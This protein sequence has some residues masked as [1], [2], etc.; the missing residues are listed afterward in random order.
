MSVDGPD[1]GPA[2][3]TSES[4]FKQC[5]QAGRRRELPLVG[6]L[7]ESQRAF[8][9]H[10]AHREILP[11]VA[12]NMAPSD[13]VQ[14]TLAKAYEKFDSFRGSTLAE[15]RGWLRRILQNAC[16]DVVRHYSSLK[17][18]GNGVCE[19]PHELASGSSN[20]PSHQALTEEERH[21]LYGG[22][23]QLSEVHRKVILLRNRDNLS[24]SEIGQ[25]LEKSSEAARKL[26][27][28]AILQLKDILGSDESSDAISGRT[29][30]P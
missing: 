25:Q 14:D 20:S 10:I 7:L 24:F 23:A 12:A 13:L 27:G 29:A 18:N 3:D 5:V 17:R 8:L 16:V 26:W 11:I 1:D 4:L 21:R 30:A 2:D 19:L 9:L 28:R 15:F 22:L 6:Q